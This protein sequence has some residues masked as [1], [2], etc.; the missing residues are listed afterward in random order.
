MKEGTMVCTDCGLVQQS[1]IVVDDYRYQGK[2]DEDGFDSRTY[3]PAYNPL[4]SD[5]GIDTKTT[6]NQS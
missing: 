3:G 1:R 5:F 4:L 6:L 2:F